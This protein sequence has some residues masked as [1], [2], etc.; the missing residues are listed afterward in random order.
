MIANTC[1]IAK[2]NHKCPRRYDDMM[3]FRSSNYQCQQRC[4]GDGGVD[5]VFG[6]ERGVLPL[7]G[8]LRA[9]VS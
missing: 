9:S 7:S 2:N 8:R 3:Y 4:E 1:L 5:A 6:A